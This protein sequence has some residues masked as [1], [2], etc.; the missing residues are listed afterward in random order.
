MRSASFSL[1]K[2]FG[3]EKDRVCSVEDAI[4]TGSVCPGPIYRTPGG[5][6]DHLGLLPE[7]Y[8]VDIQMAVG[9]GTHLCF[10]GWPPEVRTVLAP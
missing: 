6:R 1:I 5:K 7:S 3:L 8:A 2:S 9:A 10:K 4:S